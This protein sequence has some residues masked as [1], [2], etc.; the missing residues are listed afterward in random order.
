M[1]FEGDFVQGVITDSTDGAAG[2]GL[3]RLRL[4]VDRRLAADAWSAAATRSS[5]SR[6]TPPTQAFVEYLATPEA[7]EIW[8]KRGGFSSPNK[9]VDAER[10]P[11]RDRRGRRRRRS[12]T[13]RPSASTCPTWRRRRSAARRARAS[14]RSSRTSCKNPSDVEGTQQAAGEGR[15]EGLRAVTAMATG[16]ITA[17][18]PDR[19]LRRRAVP[20]RR[21]R[22]AGAG[23]WSRSRFLA[24]ALVFLGV[25]V[26]YPTVY[27]VV[28][29]FYDRAGDVVRR[30]R[31]LPDALHHRHPAD[32]DQE[33]RHLGRWS[34][35]R[36]SRPSA[37][38][39]P[40]SPSA[41]AGRSPSRR[42]C[43]CRWRSRC[44]RPA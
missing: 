7:A 2:D 27:T 26:V 38:S 37:W 19:G 32:G 5:C 29:S 10:L 15:G 43:S 23:T 17:E 6:T 28:R 44:S 11:G 30:P 36:S 41:S 39:S 1:V 3:Q 42:P 4:P 22:A 21:T 35:R 13:R 18:P 14:G 31:Q 40:C 8:A 20:A 16:S 12:P 34:C 24:P 25:W 33:Q 9:N